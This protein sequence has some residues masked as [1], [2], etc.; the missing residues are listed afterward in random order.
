MADYID[1]EARASNESDDGEIIAELN[2]DAMIDDGEQQNNDASFFRF[3]NQTRDPAKVLKEIAAEQASELDNLEPSNYMQVGKEDQELETDES[4]SS[5]NNLEKFEEYLKNPVK[6]QTKVNSFI[7]ALFYGINY[8]KNREI[9][10]KKTQ[11]LR[12]KIGHELFDSLNKNAE[13]CV[14]DLDIL[15]FEEMCLVVND[16]LIQKSGL[17]LR[18]HEKKNKFRY[19]FHR[20][21][22]KNSTYKTLSSCIHTKF[23]GLNIA[24]PYLQKERKRDLYSIDI[25]Y[26]PVKRAEEIIKCYFVTDIRFAYYRKVPNYLNKQITNR[27]YECYYCQKFFEKRIYSIDTS[28]FVLESREWYIILRFKI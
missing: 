1:F 13:I 11:E 10:Y 6:E 5:K 27:P 14:L 20:T 17:F 9:E 25:V 15:R 2:D 22:E 7:S 26:K 28:N 3:C 12:N 18:I 4:T 16:I 24:A 23:N 19:L 8:H 21:G